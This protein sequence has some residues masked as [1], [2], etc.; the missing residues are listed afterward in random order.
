MESEIESYSE[1]ASMPESKP[2]NDGEN[3]VSYV[4]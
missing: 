1:N 3:N 4:N 2:D